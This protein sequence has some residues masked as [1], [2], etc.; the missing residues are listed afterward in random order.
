MEQIMSDITNYHDDD[1]GYSGS[2]VSGRLIK[3]QLLRW[4]EPNG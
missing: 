2:L 3:G 1:D 4:N